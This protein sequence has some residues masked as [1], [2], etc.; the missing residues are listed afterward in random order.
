MPIVRMKP[1]TPGR[2][3]TA[4]AMAMKASRMSRF[5]TIERIALKP[6]SL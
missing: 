4:P 5:R 6:L 3:M 2:V 1:A